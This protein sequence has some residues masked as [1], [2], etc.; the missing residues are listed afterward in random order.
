MESEH[1]QIAKVVSGGQSGADR[2]GLDAAIKLRILHGGW[3]PRGRKA[4]DGEIPKRYRLQE[5]QSTHGDT[6]TE[7]NVIASDCTVVFTVGEPHGGSRNA[8]A[9]AKRHG[10]PWLHL[11]L[12][13]LT[14]DAAAAE[15]RQW[16]DSRP[17][18]LAGDL[19]NPAPEA[20]VLNVAGS[21]ESRA[22]GI[23][24]R[25]KAIVMLGLG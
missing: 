24:K 11:D 20:V 15:L 21:R 9:S 14:D 13:L 12:E 19:F 8:I 1:T 6:R 16:L 5:T 23:Q 4:E 22:P 25:V 3:C 18:A 7:R 2:G 17:G 10:K